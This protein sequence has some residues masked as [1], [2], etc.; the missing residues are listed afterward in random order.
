MNTR[1][2]PAPGAAGPAP[3]A[4][5]QGAPGGAPQG[6]AINQIKGAL[7]A[8]EAWVSA[9]VQ[10]IMQVARKMGGPQGGPPQG[11]P[12]MPGAGGGGPQMPGGV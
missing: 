12:P 4:T 11:G 1:F 7:L 5:P 8:D 2:P 6:G 3:A 9:L 10:R